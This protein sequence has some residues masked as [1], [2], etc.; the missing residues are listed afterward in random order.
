MSVTG[1]VEKVGLVVVLVEELMG[2]M[3][4]SEGDVDDSCRSRR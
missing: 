2:V 4:A 1:C 3:V